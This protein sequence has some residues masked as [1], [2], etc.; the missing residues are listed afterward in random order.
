MKSFSKTEIRELT[1]YV[2][3]P[4][5][6]QRA[7][8]TQLFEYL[9][10]HH[11]GTPSVFQKEI[12]FLELFPDK[13]Y[14]DALM[15][16]LMHNLMKVIKLY[17]IQKEIE[18]SDTDYQI[19]LARAMRKRGFDENFEKEINLAQEVNVQN[20]FR[21][22]DFY[23]KNYRIEI[24]KLEH[25][26]L[27]RRKGIMPFQE[28]FDALSSFFVIETLRYSCFA[29]PYQSAQ[30]QKYELPFLTQIIDWIEKNN[31][32]S[33]SNKKNQNIA[34]LTYFNAYKAL[35]TK[36]LKYFNELRKLLHDNWMIF[37]ENEC[38]FIY[39]QAMN[40]CISRINAGENS[41]L[42]DYFDLMQSGLKNKRLFENGIL[43]K[44][45]Y[46][47]AVAAALRLEKFDW[48]KRFLEEYKFFLHPKDKEAAY[49]FNLATFHYRSKNYSNALKFL[50]F[51]DFGDVQTNLDARSIQLRIYFEI[52]ETEALKSLL[53]STQIY[54][55]RQKGLGYLKDNYMNLIKFMRKIIRINF[56]DKVQ[57]NKLLH[58]IIE[59][60]NVV[61]KDWLIEKLQ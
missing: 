54:L 6:N 15:R 9:A 50:Q 4:C 52:S 29:L 17:M 45:T 60:K 43:S 8:V 51:A 3:S 32:F 19:Y 16:F 21:N 55:Q 20:I 44:F 22:A 41:Y 39:L 36:E 34:V 18:S 23:F 59:T 48:V 49:N 2:Q 58:E 7:D 31:L 11:G 57:R 42:N 10:R 24:E 40:L 35:T 47:N 5:F 28:V 14:D 61:E 53:D 1:K 56:D 46:K 25:I 26:T 13:Q 37:P 38:R 30:N 33:D 27:I 12:A